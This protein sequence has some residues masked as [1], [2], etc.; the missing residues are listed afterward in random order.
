MV[1]VVNL[2]VFPENT[3]ISYGYRIKAVKGTAMIKERIVTD[4][5]RTAPPLFE[6]QSPYGTAN[7][8]HTKKH[9]RSSP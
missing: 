2:H 9:F 5:H 3:T 6:Q 8:N 1:M 4:L 7:E